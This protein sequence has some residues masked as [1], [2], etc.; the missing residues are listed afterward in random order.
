MTSVNYSS[1]P[2]KALT[3]SIVIPVYNEQHHIKACLVAIAAQTIKPDQVILVDNN[4]TDNTLAIAKAFPFITIITESR[5]GRGWARSAGFTTAS[6]DIIGRIDADSKIEPNWAEQAK[7]QFTT[8]PALMG[9]TGVG[10][11][12]FLPRVHFLQSTFWSRAYYWLVHSQFKTHTMWGACMAV[13]ASAWQV[14]AAEVCNDD[15]IVH[16]DQDLSLCMA[17]HGMKIVQDN[18]LRIR[19]KAQSYHYL[20]KL[21]HY[22]AL[23]QSTMRHHR[24]KGTF[25]A[26]DYP[27]LSTIS[28]LPGRILAVIATVPFAVLSVIL[29]PIDRL[30]I[31]LGKQRWWLG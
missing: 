11:A 10:S 31:A 12:A 1:E 15:S 23:E 26:K 16:E 14:V 19:T 27:R 13:R 25:N 21:L 6:G 24:Q 7:R 29:W 18:R 9:L 20:P 5:Q 4:C 28:T 30:M 3:L 8:D 2:K 22:A 17:A